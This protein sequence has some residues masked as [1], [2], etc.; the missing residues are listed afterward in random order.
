M[1]APACPRKAGSSRDDVVVSPNVDPMALR[2]EGSGHV[3]TSMRVATINQTTVATAQAPNSQRDQTVVIELIALR[4]SLVQCD[5]LGEHPAIGTNTELAT[6]LSVRP[7]AARSIRTSELRHLRRQW[8][9]A[10]QGK[11]LPAQDRWRF[12]LAGLPD[13]ALSGIRCLL[14]TS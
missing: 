13:E 9:T 11:L 7:A 6:A 2:K 14:R 8:N 3:C 12:K 5:A 10:K 4:A 1:A